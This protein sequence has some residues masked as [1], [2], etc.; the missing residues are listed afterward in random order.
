MGNKILVPSIS[1]PSPNGGN[2]LVPPFYWW[3]SVGTTITNSA[4][5]IKIRKAL[6]L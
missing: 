5:T 2:V 4:N 6:V 3:N 1:F